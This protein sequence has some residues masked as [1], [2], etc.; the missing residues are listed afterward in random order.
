MFGEFRNGPGPRSRPNREGGP[1]PFEREGDRD[2][3]PFAFDDGPPPRSSSKRRDDGPPADQEDSLSHTQRLAL[4]EKVMSSYDQFAQSQINK[5]DPQ[6]QCEAAWVY[7]KMGDLY[8]RFQRPVEANRAFDQTI[9]IFDRLSVTHPRNPDY[10]AKFF[11]VCATYSPWKND[12]SALK[13]DERRLQSMEKSVGRLMQAWPANVEYLR[14]RMHL[15]AKLGLVRY[16]LQQPDAVAPFREALDLAD[17]LIE[18]KPVEGYP[19]SDRSD[20]LEAYALVLEDQGKVAEAEK[21]LDAA[22]ADLEWVADDGLK[23][24][25]LATRME[26]LAD[27]FARI[28]LKERSDEVQQRA[29]EI[30]TRVP[31]PRRPRPEKPFGSQRIDTGPVHSSS[32]E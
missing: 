9:N 18:W 21:L 17:Q 26:S 3:P 15:L 7:Y 13:D 28:G 19:H 16:R 8:E 23:S 1:P 2:R 25:S 24:L 11:Q 4:L 12:P 6:L 10:F 14:V 27:D 5:T 30:D 22:M 20:V 31:N 29:D 32:L